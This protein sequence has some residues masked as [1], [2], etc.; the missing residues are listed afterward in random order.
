MGKKGLKDKGMFLVT[1][2]AN[3]PVTFFE[4]FTCPLLFQFP[5]GIKFLSAECKQ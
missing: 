3:T 1:G 2:N 4:R 5:K